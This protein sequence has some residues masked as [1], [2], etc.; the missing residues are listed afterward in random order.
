MSTKSTMF[1]PFFLI[2][3]VD[4][5]LLEGVSYASPRVRV[6]NEDIVEEAL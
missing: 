3:S 5:V 6:Y 4:A 1:T 2:Y